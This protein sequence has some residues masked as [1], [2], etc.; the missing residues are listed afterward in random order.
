[1]QTIFFERYKMEFDMNANEN[2][3]KMK[4]ERNGG[5]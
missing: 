4:S 5:K 2:L 3:K 1:M